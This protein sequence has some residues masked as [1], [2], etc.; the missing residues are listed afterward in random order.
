MLWLAGDPDPATRAET[1]ALLDS[2]DEQ[3]LHER[4]GSGLE[5]GTA[6]LRGKLGAGPH[7]MNRA[8]V[9]RTSAG[10]ASHALSDVAGA[11]ERGVVVGCDARLLSREFA[12][13][14]ARVFL[15]AGFRVHYFA[16]LAS[17]PLVSFAVGHLKAAAGVMITA[18]H[19]PADYNG[20][21]V[22][23][24]NAAQITPRTMTPSRA[25]S[26]KPPPPTTSS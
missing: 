19:N 10:V 7:R 8:V 4:F 15:G 23:W 6:G 24:A 3:G 5:F 20:Y 26:T 25:P 21:K 2:G 14:A 18:S 12:E 11:R 16:Q 17:T 9:L 1:Q 13:D 22:Y